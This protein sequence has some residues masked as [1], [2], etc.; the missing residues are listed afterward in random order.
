[1][2]VDRAL[3]LQSQSLLSH[4]PATG[5]D[6]RK[7]KAGCSGT[8]V[9]TPGGGRAILAEESSQCVR[10]AQRPWP[11]A[12]SLLP[13]PTASASPVKPSAPWALSGPPG[14]AAQIC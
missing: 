1:M 12:P 6:A 8:M 13:P 14:A 4:L 7:R 10:A 9:L 5:L 2:Q 11:S 3:F